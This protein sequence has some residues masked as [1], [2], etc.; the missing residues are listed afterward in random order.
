L[1]P[2]QF[3]HKFQK[4]ATRIVDGP[5]V[6]ATS[7][8]LRFRSVE[9]AKADLPTRIAHWYVDQVLRLGTTDQWSRRRFLEVQGML[10]E[11]SAIFRPDMLW[12]VVSGLVTRPKRNETTL[13]I[14]DEA[15]QDS[16]IFNTRM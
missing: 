13:A 1:T 11:A 4:K 10:R 7:A 16:A 12:R 2:K 8:D 14:P 6:L 5:W 3:A 15:L 9:G